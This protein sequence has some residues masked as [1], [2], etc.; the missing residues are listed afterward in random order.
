MKKI[1]KLFLVA[2]IV[3]LIPLLGFAQGMPEFDV[4]AGSTE[5]NYAKSGEIVLSENS[6]EDNVVIGI[7]ATSDV[8]GRI[9]PWDYAIDDADNDAGYALT[10]GVV[11]E[12]KQMFPDTLLI[13]IGDTVQDNS[14]ELFNDL[15]VHPMV[16]AMN[17]MGYDVWIP[18]NHEFNFGL[19]FLQRNFD[20]FDGRVVCTNIVKESGEHYVLPYQIYV[21]KGIRVLV[22]GGVA[23]HIPLWE[24]S[25]PEHFQGLDFTDPIS[26]VKDTIAKL[27]GQYDVAVAAMHMG[28]EGEYQYAGKGGVYLL[29]EEV[30]ELDLILAGHEHATYCTDVNGTWVMEPGKYGAEVAAALISLEQKNGKW[31]ISDIKAENISTKNRATDPEIMKDFKWVDD[32]SRENANTVVGE[33]MADFIPE[34]VD[35]ITG[36][37]K[38]TTMARAQVEDT[39]VVD[40]INTVQKFYTDADVSSAALFQSDSTLNK[41]DFMKKDVAFI[42]KYNNTLMGVWITGKNLLDYMEW[43]ASFYNTS[44]PGDVTVSFNENIRGYNYDMFAGV[45]YKIDVSKESGSRIVN[46]TINGKAIDPNKKYKLAVNNY[47]FGTISSHGWVTQDD[48][49]YDSYQENQ[50]APEVRHLIVKYVQEELGGKLEPVCDHNWEIIGMS[51]EFNNPAVIA[52]IASGDITIPTSEDGRTYNVRAV[53]VN[54]L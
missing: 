49:Y 52:K 26:A 19:D 33:I 6:G 47:R 50:T 27:E 25:S 16:Q 1:K 31:M 17:V 29:A 40:L 9:Y 48:V 38:V 7:L 18:G 11:K 45:N 39:A 53:N 41:G 10:Y 34:G 28:R 35:Y 13:D 44:K 22:V 15:A 37:S 30:P 21:I 43:S 42:Y 24:A 36:K 46:A 14:A 2:F 23:P 51:K 12:F 20:G 32:E 54:D 8:H 4:L 5:Y 3:L